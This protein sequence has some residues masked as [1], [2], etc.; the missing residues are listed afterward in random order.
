MKSKFAFC[1]A[2]F[3]LADCTLLEGPASMR[4]AS[5]GTHPSVHLHWLRSPAGP[6]SLASREPRFVVPVQEHAAAGTQAA[7]SDEN[8]PLGGE[9]NAMDSGWLDPPPEEYSYPEDDY[10]VVPDTR[11]YC[12]GSNII[13]ATDAKGVGEWHFASQSC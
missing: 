8:A 12:E 6:L 4:D 3:G 13:L 9:T 10:L 7:L 5:V 11:R 2:G 1:S